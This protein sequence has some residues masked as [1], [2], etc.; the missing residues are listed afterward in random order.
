VTV[1]TVS[2]EVRNGAETELRA[3]LDDPEFGSRNVIIDLTEAVLDKSWSLSFLAGEAKRLAEEGVS[4]VVVSDRLLTGVRGFEA[5]D[6]AMVDVLGDVAK[7]GDWPPATIV[8]PSA[9]AAAGA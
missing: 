9:G 5:L 7:L 6:D 4:L 3:R 2:G 1:L 8:A